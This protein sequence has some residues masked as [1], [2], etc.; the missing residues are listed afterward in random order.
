M[1]NKNTIIKAIAAIKT[2]YSYFGKDTDIELLV[3]TW[4]SLLL[5]YT[6]EEV[7]RGLYKALKVCKYAPV[8]ADI[9]EQIEELRAIKKPSET[10]LWVQYQ[11]ALKEVLYL[12]H[13]LNYNYID[14]T[15]LTQGEQAKRRIDEIWK[16]LPQE[17]QI[18]LGDKTELLAA[19]R[20]LN[21]S[22]GSYERNR[23]TK[24]YPILIKRVEANKQLE[25]TK[26]YLL[27]GF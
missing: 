17:L 3:N 27:K 8:P 14:H 23:F 7:D 16:S 2:V 25:T 20:G 13:R 24:T 19:A 21:Y 26:K 4:H 6:D 15:G 5:E 10:E 22:E 1:A 11:K 18:Y 9:I 12:S